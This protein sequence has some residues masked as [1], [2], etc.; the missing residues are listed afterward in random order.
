[1]SPIKDKES[2]LTDISLKKKALLM[3]RI[4]R[5]SGDTEAVKNMRNVRKEVAR[6]FTELNSK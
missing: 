4:K 2:I 3:M 1:M 5:S 6:L